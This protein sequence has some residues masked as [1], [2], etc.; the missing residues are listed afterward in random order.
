MI[1]TQISAEGNRLNIFA[2]WD[3]FL[4]FS[5]GAKHFVN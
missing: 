3:L 2:I 4:F 5:L 1:A